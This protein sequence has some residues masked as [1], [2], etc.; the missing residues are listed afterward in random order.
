MRQT[1][2]GVFDKY[3]SA[4]RA[5]QVLADSGFGADA[6]HITDELGDLGDERGSRADD[7]TITGKIRNFFADLFGP[8]EDQEVTQFSETVRRGG[9]V[10]KVDVEDDGRVD[11]ARMALERAG[12]T[13]V[14]E[15][16]ASGDGAMRSTQRSSWSD[17]PDSARSASAQSWTGTGDT[18]TDMSGDMLAGSQTSP[19][20]QRSAPA[21]EYPGV[22]VFTRGVDR[23]ADL[24]Q[25]SRSSGMEQQSWGGTGLS[26][27]EVSSSDSAYR[28]HF[29]SQYGSSGAERYEDYEPAY[30]YGSTLASDQRYSGRQWDDIEADARR[31]WETSHPGNAWERFKAA[32]RHAWETATR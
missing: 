30:R 29:A 6:V 10:V 28:D 26:G 21:M 27:S 3:S 12:A 25:D 11:A 13:D 8:D 9:A 17:A 1:V 23:P 20:G 24:Q 32:V 16:S 5:V 15:E 14:D 7:D 19:S 31:D 2:V 4:Q 22:R 18:S